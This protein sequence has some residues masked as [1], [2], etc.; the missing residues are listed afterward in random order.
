[1]FLDAS[2]IIAMVA[3]EDDC[4]QFDNALE[5]SSLRMTSAIA[6]WEAVAG[7]C[8]SHNMT[9]DEAKSAVDEFVEIAN[10]QI[11]EIGARA[12]EMAVDAYRN[13]GKGRHPARLNMGDCFAYACAKAHD[14]PLLFKGDDFIQTDITPALTSR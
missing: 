9:V 6:L 3:N 12:Y 7:L 5:T 14:M 10:I 2:A 1:M 11:A 13:Y 8:R 4:D